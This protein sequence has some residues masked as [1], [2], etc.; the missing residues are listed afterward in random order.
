M[1]S[2][3]AHSAQTTGS[4]QRGQTPSR[5]EVLMRLEN[6]AAA[7]LQESAERPQRYESTRQSSPTSLSVIL[8]DDLLMFTYCNEHAR[9]DIR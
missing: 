7:L 5:I 1:D 4:T 9:I 3:T 2:R 8:L 6:R